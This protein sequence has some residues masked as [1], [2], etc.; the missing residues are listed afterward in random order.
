MSLER[1][2][3]GDVVFVE[4]RN[5]LR[6]IVSVPGRYSLADQRNARGERR[7][8]ACR[9][10]YLSAHEIGI[11]G[12]VSGKVG[13]RVIANIDHLGKVEGPIARQL[14]RGF[15]MKIAANAERRE[16][17]AAK[18]EWLED[19]KNHDASNRRAD[20]RIV[21]ENL[22]SKLVFADGSIET[23]LILNLSV[24]GAA[25]SAETVPEIR[26]VLAVGSVVGRVVRHFEGGFAVQFIERQN[27]GAVE[28]AVTG[29]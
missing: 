21:P 26:T 12:P 13:E 27:R 29:E 8:F 17:L 22:Y 9:A 15:M 3:H 7:V 23:C 24:S 18:I 25:I 6:V 19:Y 5:D 2:E 28:A 1:M 10:V 4:P 14:T 20:E 16:A 11:A